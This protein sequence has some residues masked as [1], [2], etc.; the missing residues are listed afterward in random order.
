MLRKYD[1]ETEIRFGPGVPLFSDS[2]HNSRRWSAKILIK[3]AYGDVR[4]TLR[5]II[6]SN[7]FDD[8]VSMHESAYYYHT[9]QSK[10]VPP[11]SKVRTRRHSFFSLYAHRSTSIK[12]ALHFLLMII[13]AIVAHTTNNNDTSTSHSNFIFT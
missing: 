2:G 3:I 1:R 10:G 5:F 9:A 12:L 7:T 4:A 6:D 8:V 13:H 11:I